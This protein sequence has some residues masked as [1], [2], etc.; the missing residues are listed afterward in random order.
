MGAVDAP[1][2]SAKGG[3]GGMTT[4]D[5][6][7]TL[8]EWRALETLKDRLLE[9]YETA[10]RA[11]LAA[12]WAVKEFARVAALADVLVIVRQQQADLLQEEAT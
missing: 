7:T 10:E 5:A 4:K 6:Q 12:D 11:A 9:E 3:G 1:R 8:T 2:G